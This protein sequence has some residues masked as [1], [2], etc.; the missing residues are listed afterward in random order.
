[1]RLAPPDQRRSLAVVVAG[2]VNR[3]GHNLM[4][5]PDAERFARHVIQ[6]IGGR[7]KARQTIDAESQLIRH[8]WEQDTGTLGRILRAHLFVEHF[9]GEYIQSENPEL[10]SLEDARLT[11]AQKVALI[12]TTAP[13]I[14][15]LLPGIRRLNAIRNRL[16][17]SL[18]AEVTKEDADALLAVEIFRELRN[19]LAEPATPSADPVDILED[20]ASHAGIMLHNS[21]SPLGEIFVEALRLAQDDSSRT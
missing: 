21:A 14:A 11:F 10:G 1:M 18:R 17:H 20:F 9:L 16:V 19:V 12:G 15:Y 5:M 3:W 13:G 4:A 8:R 6:L 2:E 7:E